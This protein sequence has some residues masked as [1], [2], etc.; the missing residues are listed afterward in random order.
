M[1]NHRDVVTVV[2]KLRPVTT[3][4]DRW[5]ASA[6][7][8]ALERLL[9]AA[10]DSSPEPSR[11]SRGRRVLLTTGLTVALVSSGAGIAAATGHLPESFTRSLSFWATE[12]DGTVDV[13]TARRVAQ[14]PGPD[15]KVLSV[16]SAKGRD[17]RTCIAPLFEA[18]GALDRPAPAN[19]TLAGGQCANANPR[20]EPFGNGGGSADD[21]GIHTMWVTAGNAVRGELRLSDGTVRPALYAEGM[22]FIWYLASENVDPPVLVGYDAAGNVVAEDPQPNLT[23]RVPSRP[24]D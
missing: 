18:P 6:R 1:T 2:E 14:A 15:G 10:A 13:Q 11:P 8:A 20:P 23:T 17:G 24:G 3:V 16:W 4:E 19:F 12:T 9:I 21:R 22:F 7:H 5:P